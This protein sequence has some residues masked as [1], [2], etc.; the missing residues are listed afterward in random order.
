MYFAYFF[1]MTKIAIHQNVAKRSSSPGFTL[2]ELM[3]VIAILGIMVMMVVPNFA[4]MQQEARMR[5]GAQ[6]IA[7]DFRQI[8]ERA[9]ATSQQYMVARAVNGRAYE[10]TDPTG[11]V[12]DYRLGHSGGNLYFGTSGVPAAGPPEAGVNPIPAD[13]WGFTDGILYFRARGAATQGVAYL[14]NGKDD[15]AV[16][17]NR[18]G[19]VRVYQFTGGQWVPK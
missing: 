13:G 9:L 8:R 15:Y 7:Q 19:K 6:E 3:V 1:G 11:H 18:L 10:V 5:A 2:V 4:S 14:T 12:T 16:G 17:V